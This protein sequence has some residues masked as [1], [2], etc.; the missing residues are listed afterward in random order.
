MRYYSNSSPKPETNKL[1]SRLYEHNLCPFCEK[2]RM[3]LTAKNIQFQNCQIDL[4]HKAKWHV[5][6]NGGFV[7]LLE[8]PDDHFIYESKVIMEYAN[9]FGKD[10]GLQLYSL[11]PK[12]SAT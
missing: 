10:N 6:I 9:D 1:Y 5:E 2:A 4:E 8:F 3:A 7:P 12:W 11:D